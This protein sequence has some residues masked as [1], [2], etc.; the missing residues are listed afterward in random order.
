[1]DQPLDSEKR[2]NAFLYGRMVQAAYQMF[3]QPAGD[4]LRPEPE[5]IPEGWELG[6][7]IQMSD[8]VLNLNKPEFYGIIAHEIKNPDSRIVAIRGTEGW[9]EWIDDFMA[10]HTPFQVAAAG[11]VAKG[12]DRIYGSLKIIKRPLRGLKAAATAPQTFEG[13][14]AQQL[15]KEVLAREAERSGRAMAP[16][17]KRR[18]RPT[19]VAGHSLGAALATLFVG[20]NEA[21]KNFDITTCCT[22]A[23]PRVGDPD[24]VRFFD[25]LPINS[26]R[27]VNTLDEV[28][29]LAPKFMD[30]DHV[31]TE[32]S[33]SSADFAKESIGCRHFLETY[34]HS[35]DPTFAVR[36]ECD[37]RPLTDL[38]IAITD[39][40]E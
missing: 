3:L 9:R 18:R 7:W 34:L 14:F 20:E 21:E 33:F 36:P 4:P 24:F 16:G 30:Y 17:Q 10:F 27:I 22:F 2:Q 26:W 12:F 31:A 35:L 28:P 13:T 38:G 6:A 1:M 11:R 5:G 29:K 40:L 37:P 39:P 32:Y 8:F 15:E 19:V 23:S 25:R